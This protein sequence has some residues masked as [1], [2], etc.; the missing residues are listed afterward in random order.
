MQSATD[1]QKLDSAP[2]DDVTKAAI[3]KGIAA[4]ERGEIVSQE[5]ARIIV[6][7]RYQAGQKT[8]QEALP[9]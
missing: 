5:Q 9:A 3:E 7:K 6:R 1:L 4:A 2:V 8:Q